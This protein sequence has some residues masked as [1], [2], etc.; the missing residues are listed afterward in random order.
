MAEKDIELDEELKKEEKETIAGETE[1]EE[2]A[3]EV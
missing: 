3:S 1:T 2:T